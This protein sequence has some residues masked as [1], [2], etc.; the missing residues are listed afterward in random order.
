[1]TDTDVAVRTDNIMA[2]TLPDPVEFKAKMQA[3][4]EFQRIVREQLNDLYQQNL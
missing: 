1:M 4:V 3:I 2:L